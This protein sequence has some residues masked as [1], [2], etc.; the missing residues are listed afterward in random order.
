MKRKLKIL[1]VKFLVREGVHVSLALM[2]LLA[3]LAM[4]GNDPRNIVTSAI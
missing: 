3:I 4:R 1:E 2:G